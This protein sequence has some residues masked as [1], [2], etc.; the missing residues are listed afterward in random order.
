[1]NPRYTMIIQWSETDQVFVV[2]I[3]EFADRV[4]MPCTEGK[5]YEEAARSGQEVVETFL[6]IWREN[7][8]PIPQP[9]GYFVAA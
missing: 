5:T 1:M 2:T 8:E 4:M 9:Q 6:E 7:E 3:P